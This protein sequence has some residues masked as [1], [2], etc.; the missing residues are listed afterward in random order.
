MFNVIVLCGGESQRFWDPEA[1]EGLKVL[2][3]VA[4]KPLLHHVMGQF[5]PHGRFRFI[6]VAGGA[7]DRIK[8]E[9]PD[10][11]TFAHQ[12]VY[13]GDRTQTGGRIRAVR[14]L[15]RNDPFFVAY[16]DGLSNID[17]MEMMR[18][19]ME[20]GMDATMAVTRADSPYGHAS[21]KEDGT[22]RVFEEKP[23]LDAWI[24]AGFFILEP[25]VLDRMDASMSF[26]GDVL[27]ILAREGRV[28]ALLH[29]GFWTAIDTYKDLVHLRRMPSF[30][31]DPT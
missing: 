29:R 17:F 28:S 23:P 31:S 6:L 16:G 24:N 26:E 2:A 30:R 11:G 3:R 9:L 8:D 15:V 13:T 27:P 14:E 1:R 5:R 18:H 20:R 7:A 10:A 4:G 22:I 12:V 19:H 21:L 25:N